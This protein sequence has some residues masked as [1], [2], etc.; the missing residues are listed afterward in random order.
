MIDTL[1]LWIFSRLYFKDEINLIVD[2]LELFGVD[3]LVISGR[4]KM[5]LYL[6]VIMRDAWEKQDVVVSVSCWNVK[7]YLCLLSP[8]TEKNDIRFLMKQSKLPRD[9]RLSLRSAHQDT[10]LSSVGTG[11]VPTSLIG[12]TIL[13]EVS[14]HTTYTTLE[15]IQKPVII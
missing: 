10:R 3:S 11:A 8:L 12:I 1:K 14:L 2:S 5:L 4:F 15:I 7:D 6:V 13:T 9:S